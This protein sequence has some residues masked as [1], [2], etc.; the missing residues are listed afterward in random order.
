MRRCIIR[1]RAAGDRP[2]GHLLATGDAELA[3]DEDVERDAECR[4]DLVRDRHATPRQPQNH[5]IGTPSV[6]L[7]QPGQNPAGIP[8][9]AEQSVL[10]MGRKLGHIGTS[11]SPAQAPD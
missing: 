1:A 3:D 10:R 5:D 8:P 11:T 4:G 7:D 9:V 6:V 2:H